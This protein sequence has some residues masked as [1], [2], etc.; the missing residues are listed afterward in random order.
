MAKPA[1]GCKKISAWRPKEP[2]VGTATDTSAR[3][4][5]TVSATKVPPMKLR[6]TAGPAGLTAMALPRKRA[7]AVGGPRP[8]MAAWWE[9]SLRRRPDSRSSRAAESS[10]G[11]CVERAGCLVIEVAATG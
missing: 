2:A 1:H 5:I 8:I 10:G 6:I 9:E 3:A 11:G 7:G 4:H